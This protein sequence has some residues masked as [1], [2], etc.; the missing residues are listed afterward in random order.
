M[1]IYIL[2]LVSPFLLLL[3]CSLA[4]AHGVN[5]SLLEGKAVAVSFSY[6]GGEPMSYVEAKVFGPGSSPDLEFQNGRTDARGIFAFVPD[7]PGKWWVEVEDNQGHKGVFQADFGQNDKVIMPLAHDNSGEGPLLLK[8]VL[9]LSLMLN[10][11]LIIRQYGK[12]RET[13]AKLNG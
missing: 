11:A 12:K 3:A 9:A 2:S 4:M 10:L 8:V 1:R 6:S 5:Y 7:Q 13:K